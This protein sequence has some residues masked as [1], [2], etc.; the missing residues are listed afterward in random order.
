MTALAASGCFPDSRD[1]QEEPAPR[2][3]DVRDHGAILDGATDCTAAVQRAADAAAVEGT[4]IYLPP[5]VLRLAKPVYVATPIR[6]DG[7]VAID[8]ASSGAVNIVRSDSPV[9]LPAERLTGLTRGSTEIGGLGGRTGDLW[10][11]SQDILINRNNGTPGQSYNKSELSRAATTY[12]TLTQPLALSYSPDEE[13]T[14]ILYPMEP[15]LTVDGLTILV[16]GSTGTH[17]NGVLGI[18][19]SDVAIN[20][21]TVTNKSDLD[22]THA[23]VIRQCSNIEV[24]RPRI[25][26]FRLEG[27]G[28]G[29]ARYN[30]AEVR[31]NDAHI[32]DCRH[33]VSGLWNKV[34]RINGGTFNGGLDDHWCWGFHLNDV[35]STVAPGQSHVQIA[36]ADVYV[37]GGTFIGGRNLIG[38]RADT[39]ELTGT[40]KLTNGWTWAASPGGDFNWVVGYTTP[41]LPTFNYGRSLGSPNLTIVRDGEVLAPEGPLIDIVDNHGAAFEH[42]RWTNIEIGEVRLQEQ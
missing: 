11:N 3:T 1:A 24:N 18:F 39:P 8:A 31:I 27:S 9:V 6:C 22:L 14:A 40:L 29:I 2:L 23:V 16:D 38:I 26:G 17:P 36:G 28:Y 41:S 13:L 33:A 37:N 10:L 35:K 25:Q 12:G 21:P 34:T 32:T 19:R 42:N 30:T 7:V 4:T 15:L 20:D 5:G